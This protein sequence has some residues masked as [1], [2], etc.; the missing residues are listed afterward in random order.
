MLISHSRG[1]GREVGQE[2]EGGRE[3]LFPY[4]SFFLK[5]SFLGEEHLKQQSSSRFI[6][7]VALLV[8]H[9][10]KLYKVI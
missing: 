3:E 1:G 6:F 10:I 2:R 5:F 7:F 9:Y 4:L 8:K